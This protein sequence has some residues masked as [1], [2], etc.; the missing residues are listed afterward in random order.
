LQKKKDEEIALYDEAYKALTLSREE[1]KTTAELANIARQWEKLQQIKSTRY[2]KTMAAA[3]SQNNLACV[4][5]EFYG[6]DH[7]RT[8]DALKSMEAAFATTM[9]NIAAGTYE[10]ENPLQPLT[11]DEEAAVAAGLPPRPRLDSESLVHVRREASA[12]LSD[13]DFAQLAQHRTRSCRS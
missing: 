2:P 10:V 7:F 6:V 9:D 3:V 13:D 1:R 4:L 11:E 5:H 8:K 12:P